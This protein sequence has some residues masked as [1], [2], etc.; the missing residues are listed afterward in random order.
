MRAAVAVRLAKLAA[1]SEGLPGVAAAHPRS[2]WGLHVVSEATAPLTPPGER[3]RLSGTSVSDLSEC[4]LR[5]FLSHEVH[6]TKAASAAMGFGGVLHALADEVASGR[7]PPELDAVMLRLDR[8]WNQ[9]AYEAPWLSQQQHDAARE[10][11]GRFLTWHLAARGRTLLATELPFTVPLD[12]PGG[13][14]LLRGF[15]DRVELDR[16]GRVHVVDLKTAKTPPSGGAVAVHPQLATYQL[17]V[18]EGILEDA[19][20]GV[21]APGA[22]LELGGAELV[23]LRVAKGELPKVQPQPPLEPDDGSTW[24]ER[25]LDDAVRRVLAEDFPASPGQPHCDRC[26]FRRCCPAQP[27]GKQVVE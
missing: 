18:R 1:G 21:V 8:V 19:L 4:P 26:D 7:T 9:L 15:I 27:E 11:L 13:P 22:P 25:L 3:V 20:D 5:W 6:A 16:D 10:A 24:I 23:Q 12:L 2:W 17:A 14:V